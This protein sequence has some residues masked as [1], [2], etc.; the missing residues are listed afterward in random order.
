ML[1]T[2]LHSSTATNAEQ[3]SHLG[4]RAAALLEGLEDQPWQQRQQDRRQDEEQSRS[5]LCWK[6]F[7]PLLP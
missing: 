2:K 4:E 7:S 5:G 3:K 6:A 1:L